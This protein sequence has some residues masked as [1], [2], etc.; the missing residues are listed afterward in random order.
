M[1][2]EYSSKTL[3]SAFKIAWCQKITICHSL[4][5]LYHLKSQSVPV[6]LSGAISASKKKGKTNG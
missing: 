1:Q 4:F 3:A 2:V 5:V 6:S